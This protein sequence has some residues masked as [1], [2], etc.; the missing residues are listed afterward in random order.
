ML[1]RW[2]RVVVDVGGGVY[3]QLIVG[4]AAARSRP[5]RV[6]NCG[7]DEPCAARTAVKTR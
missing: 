3:F 6:A 5:V 4:A 7:T 1:K 2:Q